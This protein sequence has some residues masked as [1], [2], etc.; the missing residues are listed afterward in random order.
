M[1]L[2]PTDGA[3]NRKPQPNTTI[4]KMPLSTLPGIENAT[5]EN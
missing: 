1:D 5:V 4:A 3:Q 2:M